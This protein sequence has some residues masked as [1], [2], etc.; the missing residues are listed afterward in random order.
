MTS[1]Y[2]LD[3]ISP[4]DIAFSGANP[5]GETPD[6]IAEDETYE[7][8]KDSVYQYG[9]LVPI[10]VRR[11]EDETRKPFLLVDG[12]RRLR[13]ALATGI[14]KIPAHITGG[15]AAEDLVQAFHIH[16]LRKQ[17]SLLAQTRALKRIRNELR[18]AGQAKSDKELIDQLRAKTGCSDTRL[19]DLWR[20]SK[21]SEQVLGYVDAGEIKVSHLIQNEESFV[22]QLEQKYPDVLR[23]LGKAKVRESLVQKA[24]KRSLTST[25][26]LIDNIV[27]VIARAASP[28]EKRYAAQLLTDFIDNEDTPA[29]DVLAKFETRYPLAKADVLELAEEIG[30]TAHALQALLERLD[31]ANLAAFPKPQREIRRSLF[32]LKTIISAKLR[33]LPR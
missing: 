10:V 2:K 28:E 5:R 26:A 32:S 3:E 21:Y 13:A 12:E 30:K 17:W 9:V 29:E 27:P 4:A 31:P 6:Q 23:N 11:Q 8:L 33:R 24:R 1:K 22:E 14:D 15:N 18:R 19:M 7:Q 20:A 25:R 16:M